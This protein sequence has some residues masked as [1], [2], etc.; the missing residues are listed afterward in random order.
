MN[1][2]SVTNYFTQKWL[3]VFTWEIAPSVFTDDKKTALQFRCCEMH[4]EFISGWRDGIRKDPER[5]QSLF[6][7][8]ANTLGYIVWIMRKRGNY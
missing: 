8:H 2:A 4:T 6:K 5:Q 1:M 7:S 3:K